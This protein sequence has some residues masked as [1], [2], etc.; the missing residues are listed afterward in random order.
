MSAVGL[1]T[2]DQL[3]SAFENFSI[4]SN[5]KSPSPSKSPPNSSSADLTA[6]ESRNEPKVNNEAKDDKLEKSTSENS[7]EN[8]SIETAE[9][10]IENNNVNKGE[11]TDVGRNV[12]DHKDILSETKSVNVNDN[13]NKIVDH[14]EIKNGCS[15]LPSKR[16]FNDIKTIARKVGEKIRPPKPESR[17]CFEADDESVKISDEERLEQKNVSHKKAA[18]MTEDDEFCSFT[19][20]DPPTDDDEDEKCEAKEVKV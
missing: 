2:K 5:K 7:I 20:S 9:A 3:E 8:G 18:A 17:V 11:D 19:D 13:V 6:G 1:K 12:G 4:N 16:K 15:P 14:K 10:V